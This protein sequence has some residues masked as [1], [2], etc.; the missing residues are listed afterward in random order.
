MKDIVVSAADLLK[1]TDAL[2]EHI[3]G[4]NLIETRRDGA[5]VIAI[6]LKGEAKAHPTPDKNKGNGG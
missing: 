1:I 2:P 5:L 3:D 4:F 6:Y